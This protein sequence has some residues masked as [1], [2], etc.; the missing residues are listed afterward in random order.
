MLSKNKIKL[1]RFLGT[2]KYREQQGLFVAEGDKIVSDLLHAKDWPV[3]YLFGKKEWLRKLSPQQ[4]EDIEEITEISYEELRRISYMKSPHNVL[5]LTALPDWAAPPAPPQDDLALVLENI[6]DPGNLGTIIRTATWFGIRHIFCSPGSV[7][8]FNPKVVQASMGAFIHTSVYYTDL[9]EL[10]KNALESGVPVYGTF[11]EGE[12]LFTS[13]LERQG[14]I[15]FG[16]ESKGISPA[17][18]ALIP[19][20]LTIPSFPDDQPTTNSLNISSSTAILCAEF[21]RRAR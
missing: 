9:S 11:L 5:A 2:K 8:V 14:L 7:D 13:P 12:P 21:R 10:I 20:K 15:V 19:H 6:Q 17:L 3:R 4:K 18:T 1:I 16:N